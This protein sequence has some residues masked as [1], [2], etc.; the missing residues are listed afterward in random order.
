[1]GSLFKTTTISTPTITSLGTTDFTLNEDGSI[2]KK[3]TSTTIGSYAA[4]FTTNYTEED[5]HDALIRKYASASVAESYVES[6]SD[7]EL[8]IALQKLGLLEK[9]L[10]TKNTSKM[11]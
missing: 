1:M 4:L 6:L 9:E 3:H 5:R 8:E 11:V 10:T 7:E 2:N